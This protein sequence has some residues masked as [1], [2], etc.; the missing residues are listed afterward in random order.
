MPSVFTLE[1]LSNEQ[2]AVVGYPPY[3]SPLA[4]HGYPLGPT[5]PPTLVYGDRRLANMPPLVRYPERGPI[6]DYG[7]ENWKFLLMQ[8]YVNLA[9]N[10]T[11]PPSRAITNLGDAS[12]K[13]KRSL[14]TAAIMLTSVA[15]SIA[16]G[17]VVGRRANRKEGR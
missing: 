1:G 14:A 7:D 10:R 16:V 6:T 9:P 17:L 8:P 11:V 4:P 12:P 3:G 2:L 5:R 15:A 13:T